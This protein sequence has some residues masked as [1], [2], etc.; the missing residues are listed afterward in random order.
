MRILSGVVL[1]LCIGLAF[2]VQA[3]YE[4]GQ[5]AYKQKNYAKALKEFRGAAARKNAAAEYMLG[6]MYAKGEGV[7][8]DD[9]Q[10]SEWLRK[11]AEHG[12][13]DAQLNYGLLHLQ[14]RGVPQSNEEAVKWYRKASAQGQEVAQYALTVTPGG[15][16]T[17]E[18]AIDL[19]AQS[20]D[21]GFAPAQTRLGFFY[22]VNI[23]KEN[24]R[25]EAEKWLNKAAQQN[26]DAAREMLKTIEP[27]RVT[28]A[29]LTSYKVQSDAWSSAPLMQALAGLKCRDMSKARL[30]KTAI[31]KPPAK[32][33]HKGIRMIHGEWTE[34]W[35]VDACGKQSVLKLH[36]TADG[37]GGATFTVGDGKPA[38]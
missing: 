34:A 11:G 36:F 29:T 33:V 26:D 30:L 22:T 14:G 38:T 10:A 8:A 19:L 5:E 16:Q 13:A 21:K 25:A 20:A 15:V 35:T 24:G 4:A 7:K 9:K 37:D 3:G 27:L 6:M 32:P 28:G 1:G 12:N 31:D 2:P 18:E 17:F 23:G